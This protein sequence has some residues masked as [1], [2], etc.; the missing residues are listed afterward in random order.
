MCDPGGLS[1]PRSL[2]SFDFRAKS[3]SHVAPLLVLSS[4]TFSVFFRIPLGI[5]LGA[6]LVPK[7]FQ[8]GTIWA[9]CLMLFGA[10]VESEI[11]ALAAARAQFSGS[12]GVTFGTDWV[13]FSMTCPKVVPGGSADQ[14]LLN[15]GSKWHPKCRHFCI[16][17]EVRF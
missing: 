6:L 12:G 1:G 4:I 9:S 11:C 7:G 17:F 14:F 15:L 13:M 5:A 16:I 2:K 10:W 8:L 3:Y